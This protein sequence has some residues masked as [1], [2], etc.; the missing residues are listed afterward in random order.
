MDRRLSGH[1]VSITFDVPIELAELL[2]AHG[3]AL[4]YAAQRA[5]ADFQRNPPRDLAEVRQQE[6]AD[7]RRELESRIVTFGRTGYRL[8]RG[9]E[10]K[11]FPTL[12][13]IEKPTGYAL[14]FWQRS[15]VQ[16]IASDLRCDP[17][18][19][20]HSVSR[21][22]KGLKQRIKT[23][24]LREVFRAYKAGKSNAQIAERYGWSTSYAANVV[25]KARRAAKA[26]EAGT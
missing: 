2:A 11:A 3:D 14:Q 24:Q 26:K 21:F 9:R 13:G 17:S 7:R 5:V 15:V 4:V 6:N 10:A 23:R 12:P 8:L 22:R 18:F 19:L 1:T 16:E 25:G 20:E